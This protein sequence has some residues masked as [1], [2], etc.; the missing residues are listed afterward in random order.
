M[1][2]PC[3][4]SM[5]LMLNFIIC[6]LQECTFPRSSSSVPEKEWWWRF[7]KQ[8]VHLGHLCSSCII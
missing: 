3:H 4:E 1:S 8:A 7:T 5:L 2:T 6:H